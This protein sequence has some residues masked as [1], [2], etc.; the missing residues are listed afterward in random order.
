MT[1]LIYF[2]LV[3]IAARIFTLLPNLPPHWGQL[4]ERILRI[5]K[6]VLY[7]FIVLAATFSFFTA[8]AQAI[9]QLQDRKTIPLHSLGY[10][11]MGLENI[12][13]DVRTIGYYTD[14]DLS[15]PIA[16]AQF[17]QAQYMLAP[18]VLDLNHTQ[19]HW[20][21]VD[22]TTPQAAMEAIKHLGLTPLKIHNG[23]ILA[24]NPGGI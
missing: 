7:I 23:I 11:F 24:Y 1:I 20:V 15:Q 19:Y 18:T 9:F 4:Q 14:K 5:L 6:R 21:I 13:K 16:I 3:F 10:Q 17:E 2:L 12:F 8:Y 22:C